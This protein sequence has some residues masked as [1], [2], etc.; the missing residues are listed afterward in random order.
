M[1]FIVFIE[2]LRYLYSFKT[3]QYWQRCGGDHPGM[4]HRELSGR[5]AARPSRKRL[6]SP[7]R[8][9]IFVSLVSKVLLKRHLFLYS[10][11]IKFFERVLY[12]SLTIQFRTAITI[13]IFIE[14]NKSCFVL[15]INKT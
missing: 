11:F 6:P 12:Q 1:D 9:S 14:M 5:R 10:Y 2:N 3:W 4:W 15:C 7:K 13:I 8:E